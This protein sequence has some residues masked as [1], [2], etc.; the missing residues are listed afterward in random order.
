MV[1][2]ESPLSGSIEVGSFGTCEALVQVNEL[3]HRVLGKEQGVGKQR[4]VIMTKT[5][6]YAEHGIIY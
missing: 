1:T 2:S 3:E 6:H 4:P 5:H